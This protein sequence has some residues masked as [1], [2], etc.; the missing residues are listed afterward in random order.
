MGVCPDPYTLR[1]LVWMYEGKR[2][3]EW[4]RTA[5]LIAQIRQVHGD[6]EATAE[7]FH[8]ERMIEHERRKLRRHIDREKKRG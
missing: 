4:D 6:K 2:S 7:Q 1:E 8:P 5:L 3:A